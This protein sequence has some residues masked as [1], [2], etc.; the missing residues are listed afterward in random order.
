MH[1]QRATALPGT[2]GLVA[3]SGQLYTLS[4]GTYG[5]VAAGG[6]DLSGG[7]ITVGNIP[8]DGTGMF[9]GRTITDILD[10]DLYGG[11]LYVTTFSATWHRALPP[12]R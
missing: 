9:A 4:Y 12:V 10:W 2:F 7:P 11:R 5:F 8:M 1:V 6:I 3:I